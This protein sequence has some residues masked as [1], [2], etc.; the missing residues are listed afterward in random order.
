MTLMKTMTAAASL[1]ALSTGAALADWKPTRPVEFVVSAGPGGG[2]DN[3]ART[4]QAIITRHELM[5][6]PVVVLNKGAG[7][8]AEAFLYGKQNKAD[9]HKL[10]F[11][12]NNVYLLPHVAKMAYK[13]E[14]LTPVAAL[15]MD[16]FILWVNGASEYSSAKDLI[17]AAKAQPGKLTIAGSQAKDVDETLAALV[18]QATGAEF[19]YMPFNGGGEA[20]VQLA[21]NHVTA[22]V[23]NPNENI[24]QWQA[25]GVKPLCVFAPVVMAKGEPIHDGKGWSDISTCKEAGI[26]IDEYRLPRT[27]WLPADTDPEVVTFYADLMKK[28]SETPEFAAYLKTTSQTGDLKLGEDLAKF[29][30]QSETNAVKVFEAEGWSKK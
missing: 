27:V 6:R 16:E 23:N 11:A 26:N 5:D 9:P 14:D 28:I 8:G 3:F 25:G 1:L 7:S 15:A 21:G 4:I 2:T 20:A 30:T 22:N 13:A 18:K 19:K 24:G 12:T 17:E 29:I 10:I